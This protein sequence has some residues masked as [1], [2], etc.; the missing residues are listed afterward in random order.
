MW[1]KRFAAAGLLHTLPKDSLN[2]LSSAFWKGWA[3]IFLAVTGT[4]DVTVKAVQIV[5]EVTNTAYTGI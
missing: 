1:L 5:Q 3:T 4:V 2:I